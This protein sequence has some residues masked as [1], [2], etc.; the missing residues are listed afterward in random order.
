MYPPTQFPRVYLSQG[1]RFE[2][3]VPFQSEDYSIDSSFL[4]YVFEIDLVLN[5][6]FISFSYSK[7]WVF[8]ISEFWENSLIFTTYSYSF[9]DEVGMSTYTQFIYKKLCQV[10]DH[11]FNMYM[12]RYG[13]TI[14][15][16]QTNQFVYPYMLYFLVMYIG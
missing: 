5:F 9:S 1:K 14:G 6:Y 16:M 13:W 4:F 12:L 3:I 7:S 2:K 15:F 10:V 11:I 8:I